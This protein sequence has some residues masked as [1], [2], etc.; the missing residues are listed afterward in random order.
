MRAFKA[1]MHNIMG[2]SQI[3]TYNKMNKEDKMRAIQDMANTGALIKTIEDSYSDYIKLSEKQHRAEM[4]MLM[5][6]KQSMDDANRLKAMEIDAILE[7]SSLIF[8]QN[9]I[10]ETIGL[11]IIKQT[12]LIGEK[13]DGLALHIK[14]IVRQQELLNLGVD[15]IITALKIPEFEKERMHY[16][17][18]GFKYLKY[19]V[20][21]PKKVSDAAHFFGKAYDISHRDSLVGYNLGLLHQ[22]NASCLDIDKARIC[23]TNALDYCVGD[24][25]LKSMIESELAFNYFLK[26]EIEKS[27]EFC[28]QSYLTC[29]E[30][31]DGI[32]LWN[33]ITL[34]LLDGKKEDFV[35]I[36][37][38]V[39][40]KQKYYK[41]FHF[42][43]NYSDSIGVDYDK[44][45]ADELETCFKQGEE[46]L[47]KEHFILALTKMVSHMT[48]KLARKYKDYDLRS[49]GLGDC[50]DRGLTI[51]EIK[52]SL[53]KFDYQIKTVF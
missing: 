4:D 44:E 49:R 39:T 19:V 32:K 11:S 52:E 37:R 26:G 23:L 28:K 46:L 45:L 51:Y 20:D 14:N 31:F 15:N 40:V 35:D 9:E 2:T 27:I 3:T 38:F 50:E 18:E 10:L 21:D 33:D 5:N 30:N 48:F 47:P 24:S 1:S 7:N 17:S 12:K 29:P 43:L 8:E 36:W 22:H 13:F 34:D 42:Y 6:Q 16:I 53:D 41:P 25:E